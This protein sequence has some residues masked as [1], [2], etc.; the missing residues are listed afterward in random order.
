M[1]SINYCPVCGNIALESHHIVSR[2]QNKQLE[3]CEINQIHLCAEHH[4]GAPGVHGKNGHKL[5]RLLKLQFQN[6]LEILLDKQQL[7]KE[8]VNEVLQISDNA[9]NRLFKTLEVKGN[10]YTRED[11]IRA[12]MGGKVQLE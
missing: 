4:R 3:F 12:C 8:E 1:D 7:T 11:I 9:L 5:D 2:K 6:N 10:K